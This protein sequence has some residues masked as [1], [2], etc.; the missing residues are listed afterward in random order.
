VPFAVL[1]ICVS[2][3][4]H[5]T[6]KIVYLIRTL[7]ATEFPRFNRLFESIANVRDGHFIDSTS[8]RKSKTSQN[9][10][11]YMLGPTAGGRGIWALRCAMVFSRLST[12]LDETGIRRKAE[13]THLNMAATSKMLLDGK[14]AIV[15]GGGRGIGRAIAHRFAT[16]GAA[17]L[18]TSRT[19][20]EVKKVA[21]EIRGAGG[22]AAH[23]AAD[24]TGE[25][26]CQKIVQAARENFGTIDILVNNAGIYGPTKPVEE[27]TP[28][29]WEEVMAVNLRGPFLLSRL[30]LPEMY[31]RGAG[32]I[33]NI[34]SVAGKAAFP[35]NSPY[36][37]SKAGLAGLTRTLA[38]EAARKGVRVNALSPG[39]VPETKMS[40]ELG[41]ALADY[42]KADPDQM[43]ARMLEGILQ[44]RPQTVQEIAAA[45]L[46][47]V[48]D[49]ASAIT[50]QTLNVDGGMTFY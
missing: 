47:L 44:G 39:P 20:A 8:Q 41:R 37:A 32:A 26:D 49:E 15:T 29:Q 9:L 46:F 4:F 50:G 35:L 19:A 21:E 30:V 13:P 17:A 33:L 36:A 22:R 25:I 3:K 10:S 27:I 43:F 14:V 28:S 23:I 34:T 16:E 5:S 6:N 18:I 11:K 38:A 1:W 24:V 2:V 31:K 40:Q 45:A 7:L 42:F 12:R 48:C